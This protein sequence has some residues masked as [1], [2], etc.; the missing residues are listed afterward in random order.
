M[1]V[2]I[3]LIKKLPIFAT[4]NQA[5]LAD[6][7]AK[8][9]VKNIPKGQQIAYEGMDSEWFF[10]VLSGDIRV[11]KMSDSGKE[12]T[13]FNISDNQSCILTIFSILSQEHYPAFA[14]TQTDIQALMIPATS[15]K[16]MVDESSSLR[17]YIFHSLSGRLTDILNTFDQVIFQRMDRRIAQFILNKCANPEDSLMMT[18]EQLSHELGT[19]RVVVSRILEGFVL[20]GSIKLSRGCIT[21]KNKTMLLEK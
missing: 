5:L 3:E 6:V 21:L 20:E 8:A 17:D 16:K 1:S 18:H 19:N 12:V 14:S 2:A 4:A 15:F 11:Y 9:T 13:L 7:A 10:V